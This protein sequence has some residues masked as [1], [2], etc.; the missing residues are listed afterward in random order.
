M[1]SL[2]TAYCC[3]Q[4]FLQR[5]VTGQYG[6][7]TGHREDA[8]RMGKRIMSCGFYIVLNLGRKGLAVGC[9]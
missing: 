8:G 6:A 7:V 9:C 4:E 2:R 5:I 3:Y 1:A